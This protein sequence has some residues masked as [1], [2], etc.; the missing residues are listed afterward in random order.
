MTLWFQSV[1]V[2][3]LVLLCMLLFLLF[4]QLQRTA[5][6]IQQLAESA[7]SD[8][9]QVAADIHSLR[10]RMDKLL[11]LATDSLE[12]PLSVNSLISQAL[13]VM[14]TFLDKKHPSWLEVIFTNIKFMNKFISKSKRGD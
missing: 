1:L 7:R 11:D 3:V 13:Q 6:A 8:L 10:I 9:R 14:H 12:L 4:R 5:V 2:V